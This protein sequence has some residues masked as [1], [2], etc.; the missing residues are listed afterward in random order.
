MYVFMFIGIWKNIYNCN[1]CMFIIKF[2]VILF[3]IIY[4]KFKLEIEMF[5]SNRMNKEN[6]LYL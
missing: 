3:I 6:V 5:S 1:V 4:N 2:I